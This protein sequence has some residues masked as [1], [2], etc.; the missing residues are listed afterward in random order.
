MGSIAARIVPSLIEGKGNFIRA[1]WDR[2]RNVPGGARIFSRLVGTAAPY[3]GTI[4]ARVVELRDG[5]SRLEMEDRRKIR[6][7]LRCVH[8]IALANLVEETGNIAL[9]YTLPDDARFIVT[10]MEIAY[11]KKARGTITGVCECPPVGTSDRSELDIPVNLYDEGGDEV[12][13]A[14]LRSL[15]GPKKR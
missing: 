6:N 8:A 14:T 2:L 13:R 12:V 4:D 10:G 7:H 1:A 11:L 3:T 15:V 5:Y 9:A